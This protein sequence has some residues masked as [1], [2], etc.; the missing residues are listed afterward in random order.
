MTTS[1]RPDPVRDL[2][3]DPARARALGDAAVELWEE[4]LRR[5]PD[6]PV[7]RGFKASE[8]SEEVALDI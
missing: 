8:L 7:D 4:F 6:L 3:W 2:D 5:L 1:R